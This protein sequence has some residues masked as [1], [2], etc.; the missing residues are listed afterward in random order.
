MPPFRCLVLALL[1]PVAAAH[2]QANQRRQPEPPGLEQRLDAVVGALVDGGRCLPFLDVAGALGLDTSPRR[3]VDGNGANTTTALVLSHPG[4]EFGLVTFTP[5]GSRVLATDQSNAVFVYSLLRARAPRAAGDQS[6]APT[7]LLAVLQG[8]RGAVNAI[9]LFPDAPARVQLTDDFYRR[10]EIAT[11]SADGTVRVWRLCTPDEELGGRRVAA[12]PHTVERQ[13]RRVMQHGA[14]V[15]AITYSPSGR[16]LLSGAANGTAIVWDE[17]CR[18]LRQYGPLDG[19]V[20]VMQVQDQDDHAENLLV[21]RAGIGVRGKTTVFE[22]DTGTPID[23]PAQP[24]FA[25]PA[26]AQAHL[27]LAVLPLPQQALLTLA[28]GERLQLGGHDA[29]VMGHAVTNDFT[30]ALTWAADGTIHVHDWLVRGPDDAPVQTALPLVVPWLL[31]AALVFTLLYRGANLRLL[32]HAL[33]CAR[34]RYGDP[35]DVGEVSPGQALA[36][37]LSG[38]MGVAALA[39]VAVAVAIGG[40]GAT[41]WLVVAGLLGMALEFA[42]CTLGQRFRTRDALGTVSGGPMQYLKDGIAQ[43]WPRLAPLGAG[44]AALFGVF[45]IGASLAGG[46]AMQVSQSLGLL[47]AQVP[48]FDERPWVYG[49]LLAVPCGAVSLG[50]IRSIAAVA[51][52]LVPWLCG[53]Y[54]LAALVVIVAHLG[55]LPGALGRIVA[56]ACRGDAIYGGAI[57]ALVAGCRRAALGHGAGTGAAAIAHAAARTTSAVRQGLVALLEPLFATVVVGTATALAI[58]VTGAAAAPANAELVATGNGG[59]L[60]AAAFASVA[61]LRAWFPWLLLIAFALFAWATM[62]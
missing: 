26:A 29:Q 60:L 28:G 16:W 51:G 42:E 37:A 14:P 61:A 58:T 38:S 56:D 59:A 49:L 21:V 11:G 43:R 19:P 5:D 57:G 4:S 45:C 13:A 27:A 1:L 24:K 47:R 9:A 23:S 48:F 10:S 2:A 35:Q 41:V 17:Q 32:G 30:R 40:P 34:G 44:L 52:R 22:L 31:V 62:V 3:I 15:T 20:T 18:K 7:P 46:N 25:T 8:H 33:G 6:A 36:T 50:G 39:G 54:L 55:D 53:G 12:P